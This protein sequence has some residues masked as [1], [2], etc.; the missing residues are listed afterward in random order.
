[1]PISIFEYTKYNEI[2]KYD[3]FPF[4][5]LPNIVWFSQMAETK[6]I[7]KNVIRLP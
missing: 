1:M 5:L 2:I 4:F 3:T 7:V 6:I